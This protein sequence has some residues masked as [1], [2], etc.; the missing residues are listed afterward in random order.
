[1]RVALPKIAVWVDDKQVVDFNAKGRRLSVF[2][3]EPLRPF[4]I[5]SWCT[6]GAVRRVRIRAAQ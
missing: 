5:A 3:M 4:G 6:T 2:N 1:V